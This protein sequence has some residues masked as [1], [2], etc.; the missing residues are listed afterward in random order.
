MT[1]A[2]PSGSSTCADLRDNAKEID[3]PR[4]NTDKATNL[5]DPIAFAIDEQKSA[6]CMVG[7]LDTDAR[8]I[9]IFN[10]SKS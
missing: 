8:T 5:T 2:E 1:M 10:R 4:R 3:V 6:R 7:Q 9:N